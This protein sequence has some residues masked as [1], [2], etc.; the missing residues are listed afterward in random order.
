MQSLN[1]ALLSFSFLTIAAYTTNLAAFFTTQSLQKEIESLDDLIQQKDVQF[2]PRNDSDEMY[3]LKRM[4]DVEAMF[5][6]LWKNMSLNDSLPQYERSQYAI[7]Q[8]PIGNKYSR[9]W[10]SFQKFGFA[11]NY[12]DALNRVKNTAKPFAFISDS[13]KI[14]Y[15][16]SVDCDFVKK[17]QEIVAKKAFA[18]G[19]QPGSLLK[20]K[21]DAM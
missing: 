21:F 12:K 13:S 3:M 2:A 5:N 8:Y 7:F 18:I 16:V 17:N 6:E 14:D 20:S 9:L 4:A 19:L 11:K 10:A 15:F 1:S